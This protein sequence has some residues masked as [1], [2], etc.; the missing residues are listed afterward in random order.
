MGI[1]R[2]LRRDEF[3]KLTVDDV[4]GRGAVVL[5]KVQETKT[6]GSKSFTIVEKN[7]MNALELYRKYAVLR[8]KGLKEL[9]F[10][11]CY[12][13]RRCTAQPVGKNTFGGVPSKV[14]NFLGY[15]NAKEYTGHC[16]RRTS[17][18]LLVDAGADML[19]LKR[20]GKWRSDTV[21]AGY[22]EES[23]ASKNKISRMIAGSNKSEDE[24]SC[25]VNK[26]YTFSENVNL[27]NLS[28]GS[29]IKFSRTFSNCV[30]NFKELK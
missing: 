3:V 20:H 28:H 7:E 21:A 15:A 14:A 26:V 4:D 11:L 19:T 24:S 8:P 2:G 5:I 27:E 30:I 1:F 25:E 6:G 23:M 29:D 9:R 17:A 16:L 22:I 13:N 12:W 10:F 18:T